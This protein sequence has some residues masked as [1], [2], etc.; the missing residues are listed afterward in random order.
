MGY[1]Y[2]A[3]EKYQIEK[4]ECSFIP[5]VS[6]NNMFFYFFLKDMATYI[7]KKCDE[8]LTGTWHCVVGRNFGCSITHDTKYVIFFQ[9]DLMN[10]LLFR[11]LE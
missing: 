11:S 10:I 5:I 1:V 6:L 4:V 3:M 2:D 7:K 9:V 8:E